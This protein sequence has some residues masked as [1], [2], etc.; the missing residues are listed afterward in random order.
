M[1]T[2][3]KRKRKKFCSKK[4]TRKLTKQ[5]L[6]VFM[7]MVL[8]LE[9]VLTPVANANATTYDNTEIVE[10]NVW[11][12]SEK[13]EK[14][15]LQRYG[16]VATERSLQLYCN[17]SYFDADLYSYGDITCS[18]T[19]VSVDGAMRTSGCMNQWCG[20]FDVT[21]CEENVEAVTLPDLK[22]MIVSKSEEWS[23]Q[24]YYLNVNNEEVYEGFMRSHGGLQI[25][26][27]HFHGDCYMMAKDA[28]QY[29][30]D[31]LNA[32]GGRI[33]LLSEN[34]D[35]NISGSK[36]VINGILAAPNGT[37]RINADEV[38]IN[39]RIYAKGI[40]LSGTSFN[41]HAS[42]E[43]MELLWSEADV[44]KIYDVDADFYEGTC[45]NVR[46][47][48]D[49]VVL[50]YGNETGEKVAYH[51]QSDNEEGIQINVELDPNLVNQSTDKIHYSAKLKPINPVVDMD[52]DA[53]AYFT[54]FNGN[55]YAFV[56][57][58]LSWDDA[59]AFCEE[60]GGHL[61][62]V[63]SAEENEM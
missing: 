56:N 49:S 1:E 23:E 57:K 30:V 5:C 28:I 55:L 50:E 53:K 31:T 6:A 61:A 29:S 52:L 40:E 47:E 2:I 42:D 21:E 22:E 14:E 59:K 26:G 63:G 39:G 18:G 10:P 48:N 11:Q 54:S 37:V 17:Q 45:E 4:K 3:H 24:E 41:L 16:M 12:D 9:A 7:T 35:I 32:D 27:T 15:N 38:T 62:T 46:I 60:C 19:S 36:I 51:Y 44:T 43:D 34:G 33:V 8:V 13:M 58:N 20:T 25:S